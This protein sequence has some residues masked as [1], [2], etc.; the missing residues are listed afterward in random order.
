[1]PA[2]L[3]Q[4]HSSEH[5]AGLLSGLGIYVEIL[6]EDLRSGLSYCSMNGLVV[7]LDVDHLVNDF[8]SCANLNGF[9]VCTAD[10]V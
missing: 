6:Q 2:G 10:T 1:M 5:L 3:P 8:A 7:V 4:L 9:A